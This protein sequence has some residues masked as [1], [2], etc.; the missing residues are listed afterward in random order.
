MQP[1]E[2]MMTP[3]EVYIALEGETPPLIDAVPGGNWVRLGLAGNRDQ[4]ENGVKIWH[5]HTIVKHST[6]GATGPVKAFRTAEEQGIEVT[7]EDLTA[8]TYSKALNLAGIREVA[9]ASGVAGYKSFG[10]KMGFEVQTWAVLVRVPASA[11]GDGL[12]QQWV[13]PKAIEEGNK[14]IIFDS[15]GTAAGLLFHFTVMEDPNASCE[16]ER[17]FIVTTQTA[18]ALP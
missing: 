15:K 9:Q 4:N 16:A 6:A 7:M 11:Y 12:A 8:E 2:I 1:F 5:H 18:A 17:F 13:A 3:A 14:D 10:T